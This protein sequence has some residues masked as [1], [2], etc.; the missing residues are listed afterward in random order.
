MS[1][2]NNIINKKGKEINSKEREIEVT[3][4]DT[5]DE[6]ETESKNSNQIKDSDNK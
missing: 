6:I 1:N 3:L 5:S 2:E 4:E